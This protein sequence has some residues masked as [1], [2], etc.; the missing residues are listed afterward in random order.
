[1]YHFCAASSSHLQW[2]PWMTQYSPLSGQLPTLTW[3]FLQHCSVV[4]VVDLHGAAVYPVLIRQR[5]H[6]QPLFPVQL[7]M[8]C[9]W[10]QL[11]RCMADIRITLTWLRSAVLATKQESLITSPHP[12]KWAT[13]LGTYI[14]YAIVLLQYKLVLII[15]NNLMGRKN[16]PSWGLKWIFSLRTC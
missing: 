13:W 11:R 6:G 3:P 5:R 16:L 10:E 15:Q 4:T 7:V 8:L 12:I 2:R 9:L 1:M 14:T